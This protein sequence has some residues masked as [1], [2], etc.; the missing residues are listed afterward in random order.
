MVIAIPT[1][2]QIFCWLATI[3][4][5][6][7]RFHTPMLFLLGF[8]V[9]FVNGGIT[10]VMLSSIPFDLQA[11]DTYFVVAH[12]H[13]VLIGG[14]VTPLFGAVYYWFPKVTGRMMSEGLGKLQFWLWFIGVNVTFFPMHFLGLDGMPRRVYTYLEQTGWGPLNMLASLGVLLMIASGVVFVVNLVMALR[15]GL[16]AGPNPWAAD[17]LEWATTSPPQSYAFRRI[18]VVRARSPM[19]EQGETWPVVTG[20]RVDRRE[21]LITT[22]LDADPDHRHEDPTPTPWPLITALAVTLFFVVLIFTPW[23]LVIGLAALFVGVTGWVWP[24]RSPKREDLV[25]CDPPPRSIEE[26]VACKDAQLVG[27]LP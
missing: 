26:S 14:A 19:W 13:Y 5:G 9:L 10:G 6:R 12:F 20:M 18:P 22:A 23:G 15:G 2:V 3:W 1:G 24:R 21:V 7:L 11:H 16:P 25:R 27:P 4:S 17:S 8:F